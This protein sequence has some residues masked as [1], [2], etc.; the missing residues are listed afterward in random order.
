MA[1]GVHTGGDRLPPRFGPTMS[2]VC[3]DWWMCSSLVDRQAA[4]LGPRSHHE[5]YP[6][7]WFVTMR[8]D[9]QWGSLSDGTGSFIGGTNTVFLLKWFLLHNRTR[10]K[11][12]NRTVVH[13][14]FCR[15]VRAM[16]S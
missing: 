12:N 4:A 11:L 10:M 5:L 7:V 1:F 6:V 13:D 2:V 15:P 14:V 8:W 9:K 16:P 3:A